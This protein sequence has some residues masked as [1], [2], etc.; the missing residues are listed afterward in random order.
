MEL[1][2]EKVYFVVCFIYFFQFPVL[3]DKNRKSKKKWRCGGVLLCF[4]TEKKLCLP[5]SDKLL[6]IWCAV[7]KRISYHR[8][9]CTQMNATKTFVRINYDFGW[10][11]KRNNNILHKTKQKCFVCLGVI[12]NTQHIF[13]CMPKGNLRRIQVHIVCDAV[14][15]VAQKTNFLVGAV[16]TNF[17]TFSNC[18]ATVLPLHRG[19][20]NK[21]MH[22][23][24]IADLT[25]HNDKSE[26]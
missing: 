2:V 23:Q 24:Q 26:H 9:S 11:N 21:H 10:K 15:R 7:C 18:S 5:Q 1:K 13:V 22:S 25:K 16:S 3:D 6:D 12:Y 19:T 14:L 4:E 17:K 20:T 8:S